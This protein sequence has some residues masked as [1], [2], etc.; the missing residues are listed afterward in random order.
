M[1]MNRTEILEL[2]NATVEL[3]IHWVGLI[4]PFKREDMRAGIQVR[5]NY[6]ESSTKRQKVEN[7]GEGTRGIE[8]CSEKV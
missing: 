4:V 7:T 1:S 5:R 2:R 3:K 8:K 6:S